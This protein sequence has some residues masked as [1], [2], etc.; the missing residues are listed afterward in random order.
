MNYS[1]TEQCMV[2]VCWDAVKAGLM[3]CRQFYGLILSVYTDRDI[4]QMMSW[5]P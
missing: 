3:D 2:Y 4:E 1:N 5:L